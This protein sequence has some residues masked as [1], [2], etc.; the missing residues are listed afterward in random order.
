MAVTAKKIGFTGRDKR[1]DGSA[2]GTGGVNEASGI[3]G[4]GRVLFHVTNINPVTVK[5]K[6]EKGVFQKTTRE[7]G[8]Y[9]H[10]I[11]R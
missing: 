1:V 3:V 6:G 8:R 4:E 2:S 7:D 11:R 10:Q 9:G 5:N